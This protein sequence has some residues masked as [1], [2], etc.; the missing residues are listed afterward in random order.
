MRSVDLMINSLKRD[1]FFD[2]LKDKFND[3]YLKP[4]D[5]EIWQD[6]LIGVINI[7]ITFRYDL[8]RI[9]KEFPVDEVQ[10]LTD[11][12][13]K[14]N[15]KIYDSSIHREGFKIT[16]K[17]IFESYKDMAQM[18]HDVMNRD[19]SLIIDN[20]GLSHNLIVVKIDK[21]KVRNEMSIG[22]FLEL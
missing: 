22:R 8:R 19:I 20:Y 21:Q 5:I 13:I 18:M 3:Y 17:E 10:E 7:S 6:D 12:R 1:P 14:Y 15:G 9:R 16:L 11:G 2:Y 4:K